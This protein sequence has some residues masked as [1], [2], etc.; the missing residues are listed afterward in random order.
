MSQAES[1]AVSEFSQQALFDDESSREFDIVD[2]NSERQKRMNVAKS[3]LLVEAHYDLSP[4]ENKLMLLAMSNIRRDQKALTQQVFKISDL[5]DCLGISQRNASRD[6]K[7]LS[8]NLM[9]KQLEIKDPH[10]E[11]WVL[12]QWV[13]KT[14]VKQGDFGIKFDDGLRPYL[15]GL[16]NRFTQFQLERV[17]QMSSAYA[18]RLYE[19]LRQVESLG[20]RTFTLDPAFTKGER[21][22]DFSKLMGYNPKSYTR[23]SNI[24]QRILKPAIEQIEALTEFQNIKVIPKK[25]QNQTFAITLVFNTQPVLEQFRETDL[26]LQM[27][28]MQ[29]SDP[30]IKDLITCFDSVRIERNLDYVRNLY[31][32]KPSSEQAALAVCAIKQ[33]YANASIGAKPRKIDSELP[34]KEPVTAKPVPDHP[35]YGKCVNDLE[36]QKLVALEKER[37]IA[38]K[39]YPE[40]TMYLN[41]KQHGQI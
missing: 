39:D 34:Q 5:C 16:V 38:F 15:L 7:R 36:F 35:L 14:W 13:S 8:R 28:R 37:G 3:N 4:L 20:S 10:S 30:S 18:I 19:L 12:H 1:Q 23:F 17:L 21:W 31:S 32:W 26:Y 6:L 2:L 33:D 22:G 40:F 11:D 9:K 41:K 27:K 29:I 24:N 25:F